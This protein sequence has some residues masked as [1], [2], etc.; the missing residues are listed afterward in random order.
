MKISE[1][2]VRRPVLMTMVYVLISIIA[3]VYISQLEIA[4]NPDTDMPVISVVASCSDAS[5]ELVEQQVTRTLEDALSSVEGLETMTSQ[6]S[7][8]NAF[9]VLEFDYGYDLDQAE[10]DVNSAL[11]MVTRSLPDWVDTTQVIRMD[12]M[13]NSQ[14]MSLSLSGDYDIP[15]LQQIA[16]DDI[17][18]QLERIPGVAQA[19]AFGGGRTQYQV[20]VNAD[21]LEAYGL[22]FSDVTGALSAS[23]IQSSAGEVTDN[24]IDYD[25]TLDERYET[26]SQIEDTVITTIDGQVVRVGDVA[27]VV[28]GEEEGGRQSYLNGEPIISISITASSDSNETTVASAVREALPDIIDSLPEDVH[29]NIQRDSTQ[30]IVDTM[31]EV[32]NSAWQGVVLAALVIFIFLRG[33]KSTLIISLSMPICI[34]ITLMCMSIAGISVNSMSMAGLIL[35][36]GM[37]VD[38]SIVILENTYSFRL[39]GEQSAI[40]AILGSRDMFNAILGSTLTTICVFLPLIIFKNDLEMIGIM[41]Q[42]MI[43]TVCISL[44]SSLFVSVTLVPALAGSILRL[45][46]RTQKP[47]KNKELRA[48]DNAVA[49]SEDK[50]RDAYAAV[51]GYFLDHKAFLIVPLVLLFILSLCFLG[52][53]GLSLTPQM[54]TDDEVTLSLSMAQGTSDDVIAQRLFTMQDEVMAALPEDAY[55]S[56]SLSTGSSAS[57]T[58]RISLPDITSQLYS[59]SEVEDMIR[60]LMNRYSDEEWTFSGGMG[61]GGSAIDIEIRSSDLDLSGQVADEIARILR[62]VEG[63]DNVESDLENGA[64]QIRVELDEDVA[65]SLGVTASAVSSALSTAVGGTTAV[66]LTTFSSDT[67]YDLDVILSD[68]DLSSID[69]LNR[70]MIPTTGGTSVR[71]DTVATLVEETSP[72]SIQREDKERVNHVTA[73]LLDGYSSSEVQNAVDQALAEHLVLPEGVEISQAGEMASFSGYTPTLVMIVLLAL[74]LVYAVMA[75]QFESLID[76]LIIFATI[77]LLMIGVVFIHIAYGQSFTLFSFVGIVALIGVVVNNGIVLVDWINRLVR[78]ERMQVREA[79]LSAAR[80]RLRPILMTTLTTILGLIPLAFFPGEGT[81]MIQPIAL[82]FVGGITTGAFLTLLLSPVLY[83]ILNRRRAFKVNRPDSLQ[84]QLL[85]YEH[86]LRRGEL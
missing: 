51:L 6:S 42:D 79:C 52:R 29:L 18:P 35:G 5:P 68:A 50:L 49:K 73:S 17:I 21:R 75:A 76:P 46:T 1:L 34:L 28:V 59:A 27:Q 31:G 2:S 41:F 69:D 15:T 24:G 83:S 77:P 48:I 84:N 11:S 10:D 78:V 54:T 36:I 65:N 14:V 72:L 22:S 53:I 33:F 16:E 23:N 9:I 3:A 55:E 32:Y 74:F 38:A 67:T 63:T 56:I 71:L 44:A 8:G 47:L 25:I 37:I 60:P 86:R 12:S 7:N 64:P 80:S 19:E 40:S 45:N 62:S 82:T 57:G 20:Q 70:I 39:K 58:L 26:L 81:E 43:V 30:S 13:S 85:E 61:F 66:E 4:L